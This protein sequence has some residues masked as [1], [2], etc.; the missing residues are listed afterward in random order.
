MV[1]IEICF[2]LD[3][4]LLKELNTYHNISS[5]VCTYTCTRYRRD[6]D[7]MIVEFTMQLVS[8]TTKVLSSNPAQ[9]EVY[10]INIR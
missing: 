6:R 7:R 9:G 10:S 3:T 1:N 4:L 5:T 2:Q 8:T